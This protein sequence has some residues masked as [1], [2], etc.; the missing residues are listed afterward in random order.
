PARVRRS[1]VGGLPAGPAHYTGG[2][3][4]PGPDTIEMRRVFKTMWWVVLV[5]GLL[6]V[7]FGVFMIAWPKP[8]LIAFVWLFGIY[9]ILDGVAS[10]AHVWRT[11]SHI[12]MGIGLGLV[13]V[14]AG[15]VAL[16]WPGVT[17]VAVLFIVAAWILLLG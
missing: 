13:S 16:I 10:F 5:R 12:G 6:M 1:G 4:L 3:T 11:R 14:L 15:L 7:A 8:V 17:A 2:M 9:A